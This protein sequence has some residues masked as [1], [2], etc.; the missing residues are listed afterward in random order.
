M[1]PG[2]KICML[3]LSETPFKLENILRSSNAQPSSLMRNHEKSD[4]VFFLAKI[5]FSKHGKL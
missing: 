3:A 1:T 4:R 2:N 5:K